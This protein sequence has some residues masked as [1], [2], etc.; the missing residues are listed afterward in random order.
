[1]AGERLTPADVE[2]ILGAYERCLYMAAGFDAGDLAKPRVAVV[3]SWAETTPGH[4][5]LHELA[6]AV[7]HGIEDGGGMAVEFG[8]V[9]PCDGIAQGPGMHYILPLRELIAGSTEMMLR[10]HRFDA[11]VMICSCDKVIPGMLLAAARCDL[12]TVFVTGGPMPP[13]RISGKSVVVCDVKEAMGRLLAGHIDHGEFSRIES[14]A[15]T[16]A[17]TCSMMGT[18]MTMACI[19]EA[20]G[21][22][23][24]L[25]ATLSATGSK[26]HELARA[27]GRRVMSLYREGK[28]FANFVNQSS[29]RNAIRV[30]LAIGGS[31]NAV[32]HLLALARACNVSLS[33]D[34]FD[35]LS[36]ETPLLARFKPASDYEMADFHEAGGVPAVMKRLAALLDESCE[37]VEGGTV[38]DR[39]KHAWVWRKHV[40]RDID[41]PIA[42]QGG[43]AVLRG[44]LAPD[45]AVVKQSAVSAHMRTF[46]GRARV[47]DSEEAVLEALTRTDAVRS[48]DVLVVRY[49]GPKGGPGMRELSLPAALMV[50]MGLADSVAMITDGRFSGATRGPCVGHIAPEAADG[51]P[52]AAVTDGDLIEIDIPQRRLNMLVPEDEIA[53]RMKKRQP[54]ERD[55]PGG[56]LRLYRQRVSSSSEGAVCE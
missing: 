54:P 55:V 3:N 25:G 30:S 15:A 19:V 49:E 47:F 18:A 34:D 39:I 41:D 20:L 46:Q 5:H 1:M 43:L 10:A 56:F 31:S 14:A 4:V 45:G 17:G 37:V 33:L 13:G 23:P 16:G 36:R 22:S 9:A 12:P 27:T 44:N 48:G 28:G 8:T 32:L 42:P 21:L 53:R 7:K 2:R 50:G 35:R 51:G 40:I 29:I 52:I 11:A 26:R 6:E 38:A 24:P